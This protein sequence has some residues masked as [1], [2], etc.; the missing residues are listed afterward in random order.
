MYTDGEED[1]ATEN[2]PWKPLEQI[3][4]NGTGKSYE[5]KRADITKLMGRLEASCVIPPENLCLSLVRLIFPATPVPL[6]RLPKNLFQNLVRRSRPRVCPA[7]P[8]L[9]IRIA[10]ILFLS[11]VRRSFPRVHPSTPVP[12]MRLPKNICLRLVRCACPRVYPERPVPLMRLP[13]NPCLILVQRAFPHVRPEIPVLLMQL[14][15]NPCLSLGQ[16]VF[17][18]VP[19][20]LLLLPKYH[21]TGWNIRQRS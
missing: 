8:G 9:L 16:L 10:K 17:S 14:P 12:L 19:I 4:Y 5:D 20:S 18:A 15:K 6:M 2:L 1:F 21:N 7:P 11:L 13:K 3:L